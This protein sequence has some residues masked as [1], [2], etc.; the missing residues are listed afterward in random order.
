MFKLLYDCA[1]FHMLARL[2]SKSFKLAFSSTWIENFQMYKLCL[3]KAEEPEIKLFTFIGYRESK[4]IPQKCLILFTMLKP[5]TVWITT[6]CGKFLKRWECQTISPAW[7]IRVQVKKQQSEPAM[8]Q[9]TGSKL[10]KVYIKVYIV[11]CLFNLYEE[12][13]MWNA[14]LHESLSWNQDCQKKYQQLQICH[15]SG[16][17]WR[18]SKEPLDEG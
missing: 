7:E 10:E 1:S 15:P 4:G 6:N 13:I 9:Q 11:T 3:E 17:K 2:C 16:R 12:Y 5:L 18:G 8:E 14:R